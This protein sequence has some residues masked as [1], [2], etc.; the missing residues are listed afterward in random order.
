LKL[1]W[2]TFTISVILSCKI[3]YRYYKRYLQIRLICDHIG[4]YHQNSEFVIYM[5]IKGVHVFQGRGVSGETK[6]D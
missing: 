3:L 2:D 5:D 1:I 6:F 4:E